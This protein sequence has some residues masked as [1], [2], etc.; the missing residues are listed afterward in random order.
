MP[1]P[2][3]T[4]SDEHRHPDTTLKPSEWI[5]KKRTDAS[6]GEAAREI[7]DHL[8]KWHAEKDI[9]KAKWVWELIQ[10]ARDVAKKQNKKN[11]EVSFALEKDRLIFKHDA[12]PFFLD[13]IY[14][15]VNGRSSKPIEHSDIIGQ[16]GKGFIVTHI[17]S[18]TVLVKGW[19][20]G[21]DTI[22]INKTFEITLDRSIQASDE[23]TVTHIANNI[24][25]CGKQLDKAGPELEHDVTLFGYPLDD[26]GRDAAISGLEGL[27]RALPFVLAFTQPSM[28]LRIVHEGQESIFG[29]LETE[30]IQSRPAKIELL[31]TAQQSQSLGGSLIVVSSGDS[32]VKIAIPYLCKDH[33]I[34]DLGNSPR[35][36]KMYPLAKT[37]DLILP[38]VI[39]ASFRVSAERF[40]LQYRDDQIEELRSTLQTAMGLLYELCKWALDKKILHKES[41]FKT[42]APQQERPYQT[43]WVQAL[44]SLV[45]GV[46]QLK[47]VEAMVDADTEKTEFLQPES[48]YFPSPFVGLSP[49]EDAKFIKGIWW[50]SRYLGLKVP[51]GSLIDE[52]N[53]IREC[54]KSLGISVGNEQ[55]FENLVGQTQD[56]ENFA[57]LKQ[58]TGSEKKALDFLK[59]LYKLGNHYR[60]ERAQ[61]PAFLSKAIYCNQNGDFEIPENL[62]IDH[63]VPESLKKISDDLFEPLRKRLLNTEFSKEEELKKHFQALGLNIID[64]TKAIGLLYDSIHRNWKQRSSSTATSQNRYKKGI[65]EFEKWLL[66][67]EETNH[68]LGQK[69]PLNEL[70]FLCKDN[71]LRIVE[72]EYLVL[73]DAFLDKEAREHTKIWPQETKLSEGYAEGIANPDLVRN[74]IVAD[75]ISQP[76]LMFNEETDLSSDQIKELSDAQIRGNY[77]ATTEVSKI[78]AFD[79]VLKFAEQSRSP[80][81]T[82]SI[83][84]FLLGYVVPRD[85]SWQES[86]QIRAGEAGPNVYGK[87]VPTGKEREFR[88]YPCTWLAQMKHSNW[89]VTTSEDEKGRK[90]FEV[91]QPSQNVLTDYLKTFPPSILSD[92]KV[93]MFLQREFGFSPVEITGWLLT[94]GKTESEQALVESLKQIHEMADS[95]GVDPV[96]FLNGLVSDKQIG[97]KFERRNANFGLVIEK[98]VRRVFEQQLKYGEYDFVVIP[99]WKGYDFKAYLGKKIGESDYGTLSLTFQRVHSRQVLAQF[100]VEVKSTKMNTVTMTLPQANNAVDHSELYLLCVVE[101]KDLSRDMANLESESINDDQIEKLSEKIL[102]Y[103]SIVSVGED[104][105]QVIFN[106]RKASSA[107][108]EIRVDYD[109]RFT[110]PSKLWKN[111]GKIIIDWFASVLEELGVSAS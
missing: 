19:L 76:N 57:N 17:V 23:L 79:K 38:I 29:V 62:D 69:Y 40:D 51:A 66:Q 90:S 99:N 109:A 73:P 85:N 64:E 55:T 25:E 100:E 68:Q 52:W 111:K 26:E 102:P 86:K 22:H 27:K 46:K 8:N 82:R 31:K 5:R 83:L 72:K 2:Q 11:L 21:D 75:G 92:E 110:I 12:G 33:T 105:R 32:D 36:F 37:E 30:L 94:G 53:A 13:D 65:V 80:D 61:V 3:K 44:T 101:T 77:I 97:D 84:L 95:C 108:S 89:M 67:K 58:K 42:K 47:A 50:L 63:N 107:T 103:T 7:R 104:L 34:L 78:I 4:E 54:W 96:Q 41:L 39:N 98:A 18:G 74:R 48:V 9:A 24:E 14:A 49:F 88:L 15:L 20:R 60:C 10:N 81:L 6:I 87:L 59:Y 56:L 70:P 71:T 106:F 16:F 35:L 1:N 45:E 43:E 91:E 28:T 93:Q